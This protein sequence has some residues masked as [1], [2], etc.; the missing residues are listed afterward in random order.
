MSYDNWAQDWA[1]CRFGS[2]KREIPIY[3][4]GL[5]IKEETENRAVISKPPGFKPIN[6]NRI[7]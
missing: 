3:N 1:H 2:L 4:Q 5:T 6:F 7:A